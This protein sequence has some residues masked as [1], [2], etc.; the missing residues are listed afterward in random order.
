MARV[1]KL[2][3]VYFSL[4]DVEA[5]VHFYQDVLGLP[6]KLRD[7]D[8]W[9]AFDLGNT[10][11][12]LTR[13]EEQAP[14]VPS[15]PVLSLRADDLDALVAQLRERGAEVADPQD[16]HHERFAKLAVPGGHTVVLYEPK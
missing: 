7:G 2:G 9:V 16:G 12:A 5:A 10:T 3:N 1:E 11:L 4:V 13:Q 6:L 14:G 8:R 15:G